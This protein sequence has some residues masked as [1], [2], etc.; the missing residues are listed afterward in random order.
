MAVEVPET[1]DGG[2]RYIVSPDAGLT[3][4]DKDGAPPV[5]RPEAAE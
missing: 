4:K 1:A 2:K 5:N 3:E